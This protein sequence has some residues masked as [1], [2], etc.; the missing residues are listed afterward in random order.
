MVCE[1]VLDHN[2][3]LI[4]AAPTLARKVI[5]AEKLAEA[6][7]KLASYNEAIAADRMNYRPDD[8]TSVARAALAAWEAA[9]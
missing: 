8:H 4:L 2:R 1:S 7:E 3:R 5:A 9:Q 6:L